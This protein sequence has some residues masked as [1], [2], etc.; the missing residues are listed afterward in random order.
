MMRKT[1]HT[2]LKKSSFQLRIGRKPNPEI[3]NLLNLDKK[4]KFT[5][6]SVSV[7]LQAYS[8]SGAGGVS[9]QLPMKPKKNTKGDSNYPFL[10]LDKKRQRKNIES[11]DSDKPQSAI[12]GTNYTVTTPNGGVLHEK[13]IIKPI[14]DFNKEQSNRGFG[15]PIYQITIQTKTGIGDKIGQRIRDAIIGC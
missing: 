5:K 11:A 3:S 2:Q 1:L 4:E 12:S 13:M 14:T 9:D 7:T 15:R 8:F 10:F 6:C